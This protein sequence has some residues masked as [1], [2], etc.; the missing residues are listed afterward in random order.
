[1][2]VDGEK[3]GAEIVE[4]CA[5]LCDGVLTD[6]QR[7]RLLEMLRADPQ[8]RQD[9]VELMVLH[10]LLTAKQ[11]PPLLPDRDP[12]AMPEVL[13]EAPE[14]HAFQ[15]RK[16]PSS[17]TTRTT[18]HFSWQS[19]WRGLARDFARE[20]FALAI[21]ILVMISGGVLFWNLSQL[22][23]PLSQPVAQQEPPPGI[24]QPQPN[25]PPIENPK[26]QIPNPL[27]AR[28][29]RT[30]DATWD[31]QTA[32]ANG[33]ALASDQKL[34]LKQGL[35]EITFDTGATVILEGPAEFEVGS[36]ESPTSGLRPPTSA[37]SCSLNLGKLFAHVPQRATG[38]TVTTP[39][40]TIV[41]QG[42]QFGVLVKS[43]SASPPASSLQPPAYL[44]TEV[45]VVQG[46]VQV[47]PR[48]VQAPGQQ[49]PAGQPIDLKA[50]EAVTTEGSGRS[51]R[52]IEAGKTKFARELP[53]EQPAK[54]P[55]ALKPLPTWPQESPLLP[56]DIVAVA[57]AKTRFHLFKIDPR[58]GEQKLL[59]EGI[60]YR[61]APNDH[62]LK[63]TSIAVEPDG[64]ILV[65]AQGLSAHDA[66]LLRID[67]RSG[68]IAV[69]TRGGL[70]KSGGITGL[71]VA[72]DGVIYASYQ[73]DRYADPGHILKIEPATGK[74]TPLAR[75]GSGIKG[76]STDANGRDLLVSSSRE[77]TLGLVQL[78]TEPA[79]T[80]WAFNQS[81]GW[82][83]CVVVNAQGRIFVGAMRPQAR[84]PGD[85]VIHEVGRGSGHPV[86]ALA[87]VPGLPASMACEAGG[88]LLLGPS[89]GNYRVHRLDV[90][91]KKL[92]IVTSDGML[93]DET[94]LTVAPGRPAA[95]GK[96]AP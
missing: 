92:T 7:Q 59:A 64:H 30:V 94:F 96:E 23:P 46:V 58:T 1:M 83:G 66:G 15:T 72:P 52:K 53:S 9:Y 27:V 93:A 51:L 60:P 36:P 24:T 89:N 85:H 86:K 84:G 61:Q 28:L 71:A 5:A 17:A 14:P 34:T 91:T 4:L 70:L 44:A 22:N 50:G 25:I 20:P 12:K 78:A 63:W 68:N 69:V 6:A 65:G 38:F 39:T 43:L 82:F 90:G 67:P 40:M 73:S 37:N 87:V 19:L 54:P 16:A 76:I 26:S 55:L 18:K 56:G 77:C 10:T 33:A 42:T 62:G 35:A 8:V 31:P 81:L 88:N 57:N 2:T 41:D 45:E 79:V 32:L 80:P 74:V 48:V 11:A 75:F 29:T 49:A 13:G 47:Q 95:V 3:F 21:L